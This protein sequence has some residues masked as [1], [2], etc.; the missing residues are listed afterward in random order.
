MTKKISI[1]DMGSDELSTLNP[2]DVT[3]LLSNEETL[4]IFLKLGYAWFYDYEAADDSRVGLHALLK[5]LRHSDGFINAKVCLE[6][7]PNI[8]KLFA[9][10]IALKVDK[11]S[12]KPDYIVGVPTA[13]TKLGE[14]VA[15]IV[16]AK[17]INLIKDEGGKIKLTTSLE[18]D[19]VI[20]VIDD[21]CTKGT[22]FSE[23]IR[24]IKTQHK[25]S[26]VLPFDFVI[27]NRGGLE[28]IDI[29]GAQFKVMAVAERRINDWAEEECQLC[30]KGSK[31]IKPK[32]SDENWEKITTPQVA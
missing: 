30:K 10:Q 2:N 17:K 12:I 25:D 28:S 18:V 24:E 6:E 19:S 21:I 31:P 26:H 16:D 5:S 22:G 23:A 11:L 27:V 7:H 29:N 20:L 13:A 8:R 32:I 9:R 1:L 15:E 14:E 4:H 3:H